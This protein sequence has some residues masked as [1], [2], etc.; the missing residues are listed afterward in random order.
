M[1]KKKK[2]KKIESAYAKA[3]YLSDRMEWKYFVIPNK[4]TLTVMKY[5]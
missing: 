1:Q 5:R 3:G 4:V 2:K